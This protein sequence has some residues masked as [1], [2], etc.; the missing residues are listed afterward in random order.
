ME[1]TFELIEP[2]IV[3][4]S[5]KGSKLTCLFRASNSERSVEAVAIVYHSP[6]SSNNTMSQIKLETG[7]T[8]SYYLRQIF[9]RFLGS[10]MSSSVSRVT[11]QLIRTISTKTSLRKKEKRE[12]TV[13]AFQSVADQFEYVEGT[14]RMKQ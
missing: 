9:Q 10:Q 8:I 14:W 1:I 12:A 3:S 7:N 11:D 6:A 13:R 5:F 4:S 2:L